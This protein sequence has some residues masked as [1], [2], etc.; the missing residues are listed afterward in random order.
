MVSV[1]ASVAKLEFVRPR[2]VFPSVKLQMKSKLLCICFLGALI[3]NNVTA[4]TP[5]SK[6]PSAEEIRPD[7]ASM[8]KLAATLGASLANREAQRQFNTEPFLP[9]AAPAVFRDDHWEWEATVGHGKGDLRATLSFGRDGSEPKVK[10]ATL[11][12]EVF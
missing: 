10:I 11:V 1:P 8:S 9:D 6:T 12:N 3:G 7:T 2:I 5:L 4:Q